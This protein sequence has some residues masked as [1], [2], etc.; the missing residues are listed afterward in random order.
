L[1]TTITTTDDA[2]TVKEAGKILT[3]SALKVELPHP[4]FQE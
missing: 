4:T 3:R 1:T 2:Y